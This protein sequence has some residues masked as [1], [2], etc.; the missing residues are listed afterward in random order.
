MNCDKAMRRY[1]ETDN[2]AY[3]ALAVK[4][5]AL[6]CA[7]CRAEIARLDREFRALLN[8]A[9]FDAP[10]DLADAVMHAARRSRIENATNVGTG[11]WVAVGGAILS[12]IVLVPFSDSLIWLKDHFGGHFEV[13]FS[14]MLG[15]AISVYAALYIGTHLEQIKALQDAIT[16]KLRI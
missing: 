4:F 6:R 9:P 3:V 14:I 8:Q 16:R 12:S 5:H 15:V 13:P 2:R 1:L 10:P 11:K 7:R